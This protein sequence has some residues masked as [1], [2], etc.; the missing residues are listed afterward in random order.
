LGHTKEDC[1]SIAFDWKSD[2]YSLSSNVS[3]AIVGTLR[4]QLVHQ[5]PQQGPLLAPG[6]KMVL[7]FAVSLLPQRTLLV[8][9]CKKLNAIQ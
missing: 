2:G 6:M 5:H 3:L 8:S 9:S 1:A 4:P 7:L